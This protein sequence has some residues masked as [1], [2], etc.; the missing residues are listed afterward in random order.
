MEM[1]V[2]KRISNIFIIAIFSLIII[3][4]ALIVI[5]KVSFFRINGS[6]MEPTLSPREL[7]VAIPD[8]DLERG[9][10]IAFDLE[11]TETI[12]RIIGIPGDEVFIDEDGTVYIN[13]EKLEEDYIKI[14]YKGDVEVANPYKVQK[15]EFYVLGDNRQDSKDSRLIKV[16]GIRKDEIKSRIIYSISKFKKI[17]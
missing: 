1:S 5:L 8:K 17:K 11:G 15:D 4:I 7:V 3:A 10:L 2:K 14:K 16:G 6:S 12:K 9:D 13:D